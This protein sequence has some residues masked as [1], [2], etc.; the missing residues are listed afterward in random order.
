M[1]HPGSN[2]GLDTVMLEVPSKIMGKRKVLKHETMPLGENKLS[3]GKFLNPADKKQKKLAA[4]GEVIFQD[5]NCPD[6]GVPGSDQFQK[7]YVDE[8]I[9]QSS[10]T[11]IF[12]G[13]KTNTNDVEKS[14]ITVSKVGNSSIL[15]KAQSSHGWSTMEKDLYL[16]GVEIFG[17][18]RY[19]IFVVISTAFLKLK[20]T[21]WFTSKVCHI[22]VG[23]LSNN[24]Q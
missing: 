12:R 5:T 18:N 1:E 7:E 21:V 3:V 11:D 16:K 23:E 2:S 22:M 19:D 10:G 4:V 9:V 8:S 14:I 13:D 6:A 20:K 17:K 15:S 24:D